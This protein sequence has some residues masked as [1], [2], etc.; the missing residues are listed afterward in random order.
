MKRTNRLPEIYFIISIIAAAVF[1]AA[2]IIVMRNHYQ[3]SVF[4]YDASSAPKILHI[5]IGAAAALLALSYFTA[6][7]ALLPRRPFPLPGFAS[8]CA[9]MSGCM[10]MAFGVMRLFR[11]MTGTYNYKAAYAI[12]GLIAAPL[13]IV[14]GLYFILTAISKDGGKRHYSLFAFALMAMTAVRLIDVYFDMTSPLNSP[15]RIIAEM[16]M[17]CLM[18]YILAETRFLIEKPIPSWYL[19]ASCISIVMLTLYA[20]PSLYFTFTGYYR[21]GELTLF[22]VSIVFIVL[23][24]AGRMIKYLSMDAEPEPPVKPKKKNK[25]S[26]GTENGA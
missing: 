8:F 14:G 11:A 4:L 12:W 23:Y 17:L 15:P 22:Y 6:K 2:D 21:M 18:N 19:A 25:K 20:V 26:K 24:I 9:G 10:L 3:W 5:A 13:A 7:H 1:T 16:A